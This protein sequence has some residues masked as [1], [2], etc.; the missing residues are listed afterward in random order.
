MLC[1]FTKKK[2]DK[3]KKKT[4]KFQSISNFSFGTLVKTKYPTKLDSFSFLSLLA[5]QTRSKK[6][7]RKNLLFLWIQVF[8]PM[9]NKLSTFLERF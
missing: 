3:K 2:S 8:K 7:S 1:L 5:N 4:F 6:L 9:N